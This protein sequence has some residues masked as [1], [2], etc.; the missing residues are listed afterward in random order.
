MFLES[1][2]LVLMDR[3]L[4]STISGEKTGENFPERC[5]QGRGLTGR[6]SHAS[7]TDTFDW[8]FMVALKKKN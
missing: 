8:K 4:L 1:A 6:V 5:N 2:S 7:Q 3:R